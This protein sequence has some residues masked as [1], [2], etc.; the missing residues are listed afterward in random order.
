MQA[1]A[2]TNTREMR[3]RTAKLG[4]VGAYC[5]LATIE[6]VCGIRCVQEQL[7]IVTDYPV[8]PEP[9]LPRLQHVLARRQGVAT[10]S[11]IEAGVPLGVT[12][13]ALAAGTDLFVPSTERLHG[14]VVYEGLRSHNWLY[15]CSN[16]N[17]TWVI[18][19]DNN[20][21]TWSRCEGE[22][23]L[24][25]MT[26]QAQTLRTVPPVTAGVHFDLG[27]QRCKNFL[28]N[29]LST[30][31]LPNALQA[32]GAHV[33]VSPSD[34]ECALLHQAGLHAPALSGISDPGL[35]HT[36]YLPSEPIE[37]VGDISV[38]PGQFLSLRAAQGMAAQLQVGKRQ[39]RVAKGGKLELVGITVSNSV[40]GSA[41]FNEGRLEVTNTTFVGCAATSNVVTRFMEAL[42]P[43]FRSGP[44]QTA[45]LGSFGGALFTF[46]SASSF[47]A[48]GSVFEA[49]SAV[50]GAELNWCGLHAS[51]CMATHA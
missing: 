29:L 34:V 48:R 4:A 1:H 32:D 50:G 16:A 2:R 33:G 44:H 3:A 17:D 9:C 21:D 11:A 38:R 24:N 14:S 45:P 12:T 5:I 25:L 13:S 23:R 43:Q 7:H 35:P 42:G 31:T 40:G 49:N 30:A 19:A 15:R 39:I 37:L 6:S 46:F 18:S 22:V 51:R 41:I 47:I 26:A 28:Q 36:L 27:F 8:K 20:K 10:R